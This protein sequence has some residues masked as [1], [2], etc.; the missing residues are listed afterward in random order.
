[1]STISDMFGGPSRPPR[2]RFPRGAGRDPRKRC[3][4][5]KRHYDAH[6]TEIAAKVRRWERENPTRFRAQRKRYRDKRRRH[7]R[8]RLCTSGA[9][10]ERKQDK[11]AKRNA[12]QAWAYWLK[13]KAP[14]EWLASYH[15]E[16]RRIANRRQHALRMAGAETKLQKAIRRYMHKHLPPSSL[17]TRSTKWAPLL[18]YSAA[19]LRAHIEKQ[20]RDGMSW[21]NWGT[22]WQLDHRI[23]VGLFDFYRATDKGFQQ[24]FAISNHQPLLIDEHK[25]KSI[26]D[27]AAIRAK[28]LKHL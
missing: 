6:A 12:A 11:L 9:R 18:G 16:K 20:F 7:L 13:I 2:F 21:S 23:A 28:R 5:R 22:V 27:A 4:A 8:M 14:A 24:A 15:D 19:E 10:W 26:A 3:D 1:M 25:R 17:R